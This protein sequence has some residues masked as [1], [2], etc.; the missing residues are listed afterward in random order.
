M[1]AKN[2]ALLGIFGDVV[3]NSIGKSP[4]YIDHLSGHPAIHDKI[5]LC[6]K[7]GLSHS[8]STDAEIIVFE[9]PCQQ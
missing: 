2:K 5:G 6:D 1:S 3:S 4:S 8:A 7:T 9:R